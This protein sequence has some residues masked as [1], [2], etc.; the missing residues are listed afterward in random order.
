MPQEGSMRNLSFSSF[1]VGEFHKGKKFWLFKTYLDYDSNAYVILSGKWCFHMEN[2]G[3]FSHG[4]FWVAC[5]EKVFSQPK[6]PV[7]AG[8]WAG[9]QDR[10]ASGQ[11]GFCVLIR[12]QIWSFRVPHYITYI[13]CSE[14]RA[15]KGENFLCQS[16]SLKGEDRTGENHPE[17]YYFKFAFSN[18]LAQICKY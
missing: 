14:G 16:S 11:R 3:H 5:E 4:L 13:W 6:I 12:K 10:V 1:S 9:R 18:S 2:D 7:L 8:A 15:E 17:T